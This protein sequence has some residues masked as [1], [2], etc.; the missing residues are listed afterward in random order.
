M[1]HVGDETAHGQ[2]RWPWFAAGILLFASAALAAWSVHLLW[3]PCRGIMLD[4]TVL[5]PRVT[6]DISDACLRRMDEGIPFFH[7]AEDVGRSPSASQVGGFSM[8]LATAS[9]IVLILGLRLS[10]GTRL[11]ALVAAVPPAI[12]ATLNLSAAVTPDPG[13]DATISGWLW[14][15]VEAVA[16]VVLVLLSLRKDGFGRGILPGLAF[17][18]WGVTV[19]GML[20]AMTEYFGMQMFNEYNWDVPPGTGWIS[21]AVLVIAGSASLGYGLRRPDAPIMKPWVSSAA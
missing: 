4:G 16:I 17:V 19:F 10:W 20:H 14:I 1:K 3:L 6:A 11:I 9:W 12:L 8:V 7:F 5:G 21:V 15:S 13:V 2:R 18:L